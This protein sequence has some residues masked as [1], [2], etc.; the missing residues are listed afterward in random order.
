[1]PPAD[2]CCRLHAIG[3]AIDEHPDKFGMT[4]S[5]G[6]HQRCHARFFGQIMAEESLRDMFEEHRINRAANLRVGVGPGLEEEPA[7]RQIVHRCGIGEHRLN[8]T[9]GRRRPGMLREDEVHFR[10][11][12]FLERLRERRP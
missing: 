3:A 12:F 10:N 7:Q 8:T 11:A 4:E 5:R 9:F 1:M 6:D 2:V